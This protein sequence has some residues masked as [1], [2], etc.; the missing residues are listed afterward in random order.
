[1]RGPHAMLM[2]VNSSIGHDMSLPVIVTPKTL[3]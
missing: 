1:M 3:G 2:A